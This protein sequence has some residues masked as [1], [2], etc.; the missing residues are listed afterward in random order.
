M[1]PE[2]I[3]LNITE[4]C[5][6]NGFTKSLCIQKFWQKPGQAMVMLTVSIIMN[7]FSWYMLSALELWWMLCII[8]TSWKR[9]CVVTSVV[10]LT[11]LCCMTGLGDKYTKQ[12]WICSNSELGATGTSTYL[13]DVSLWLWS[14]VEI[15]RIPVRHLIHER[16]EVTMVV[17]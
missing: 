14:F 8:R 1:R 15:E 4:D 17:G 10:C 2:S 12:Q 11:L 7:V 9:H 3:C 6:V 16:K 13:L 5:Q